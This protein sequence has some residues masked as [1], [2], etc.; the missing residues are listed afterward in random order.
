MAFNR[1]YDFQSAPFVIQYNMLYLYFNKH[2]NKYITQE[3][4]YI[5]AMLVCSVHYWILTPGIA[6]T[7]LQAHMKFL[8]V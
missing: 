8:I 4:G 2:S 1:V 3:D 7:F 6:L 5:S